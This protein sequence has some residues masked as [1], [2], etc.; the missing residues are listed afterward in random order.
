MSVVTVIYFVFNGS[1]AVDVCKQARVSAGRDDLQGDQTLGT[2]GSELGE[3]VKHWVADSSVT[4]RW[5]ALTPE[6]RTPD[7]QVT[8]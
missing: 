1:L 6:F 4:L 8:E 2:S 5:P 3:S 7:A